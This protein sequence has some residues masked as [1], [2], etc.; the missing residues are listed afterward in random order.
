MVYVFTSDLFFRTKIGEVAKQLGV[1]VSFLRESCFKELREGLVLVDVTSHGAIQLISAL[2]REKDCS[3]VAFGPHV[4][5][6]LLQQARA[7]G[8]AQVV[9]RGKFVSILPDLL[10]E[11]SS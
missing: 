4:D 6:D 9:S 5:R 10:S 2:D 8:A 3:V 1:E 7:A 11:D